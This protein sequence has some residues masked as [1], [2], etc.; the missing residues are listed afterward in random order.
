[1]SSKICLYLQVPFPL[2][3][4][5]FSPG[6]CVYVRVCV[7]VCVCACVYVRVCV[8]AFN[9]FYCELTV[10]TAL[11]YSYRVRLH[12]AYQRQGYTY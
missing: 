1:M 11:T 10:Y 3:L 8:C 4:I 2:I 7:H 12:D 5:G 9:N 6:V